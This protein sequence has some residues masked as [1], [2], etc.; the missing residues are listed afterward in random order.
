MWSLVRACA[1]LDI[2]RIAKMTGAGT[3][4]MSGPA[5]KMAV[6]SIVFPKAD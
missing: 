2:R 3:N 5:T 6:D 1:I 4:I